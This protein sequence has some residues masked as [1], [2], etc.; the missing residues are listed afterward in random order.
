[1]SGVMLKEKG[2]K[3][4]ICGRMVN[5]QHA[6]LNDMAYLANV[7]LSSPYLSQ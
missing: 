5:I 1:M 6:T 7:A 4:Q 3:K 2:E